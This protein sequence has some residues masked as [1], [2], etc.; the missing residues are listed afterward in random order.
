[1]SSPAADRSQAMVALLR[2]A[3]SH[4]RL[5]PVQTALAVLGVALGVCL[6]VGVDLANGTA[7]RAF[8]WS[9]AGVAG[10]ATHQIVGTDLGLPDSTL[11]YLR[12]KQGFRQLAP[13]VEASVGLSEAPG[14]AF[15]LI[16]IDPL[17]EAP[18]RPYLAEAN[19]GAGKQSGSFPLTE[20]LTLP[21]TV[22]LSTDVAQRLSLQ[23]GDSLSIET[24]GHSQRVAL[25]AT[26]N[27]ADALSRRALDGLVISDIATAQELLGRTGRLT[28]IDA[29]V[30]SPAA[31]DSLIAALPSGAR[32]ER[33]SA[34]TERLDQMSSAFRQNLHALSLLA[35]VVAVLLIY[36]TTTF[37]V[38]RRWRWLGMLRALG[39]S[40]RE[41]IAMVLA[42]ALVVGGLGAVLGLGGGIWLAQVL[43]G[44]VAQSLNDLYFSV[45][46]GSV[47]L[48]PAGLLRGLAL[49][50]GASVLGA[51]APA[52]EAA[53]VAPRASLHRSAL[54]Q[55]WRDR[56]PWLSGIGLV[57]MCGGALLTASTESLTGSYLGLLCAVLGMAALSPVL[58]IGILR[59]AAGVLGKPLGVLGRLAA[60]DAE[61]SL[62]RT[63]VAVAA[64][65]VAV[66]ATIGVGVMVAS[67]RTTVVTWLT[68]VLDADV[69]ISPPSTVARFNN[70]T[71]DSASVARLTSLRGSDGY[72]GIR[73]REISIAGQTAQLVATD[74]PERSRG[75]YR[76]LSGSAPEVWN[77]LAGGEA[78]VSEP[79][80]RR[81]G[82]EVGDTVFLPTPAGIAPVRV[83]A[84]YAD[85]GSDL[86]L[87][88]IQ[89]QTYLRLFGDSLL[90]GL[91]LYAANGVSS[92]SLAALAREAASGGQRLF[93]RSNRSLLT[94]SLEVFDRTFAVTHA[95]WLL[96]VLVAFVGVLSA[97]LSLELERSRE[98][99]V[100]RASGL[101]PGQL[102]RLLMANTALLGLAAGLIALPIGL[103]LAWAL[104]FVINLRSFGWSLQFDVPAILLLQAV[105]FAVVAAVLAGLWPAWRMSRVPVAEA[106]RD[107]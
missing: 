60:R 54:E 77:R 1:M 101:T 94:E 75:K 26:L 72:M 86:G 33:T 46:V 66:G 81:F 17:S 74:I 65:A 58:V 8:A 83:A 78:F 95:L 96:T 48:E 10:R 53:S 35:L 61:A 7:T 49:G 29:V 99:A 89:R 106:L 23:L 70:G 16:G 22:L 107:E 4:L 82:S 104:V 27:P 103:V 59:V 50:V 45:S 84:V 91:A 47:V 88:L 41:L 11:A 42:E 30:A 5:H 19:A 20:L 32:I 24:E 44:L 25:V 90:S 6:A 92:D 2:T 36:N 63:G 13:V 93:I 3:W 80:F 18:I 98:L 51:L 14:Q 62:S 28:R 38:V 67:F 71:L 9:T 68:G 57:L 34:R 76:F 100:L 56:L 79:Y 39:V 52:L 64:L 40:R 21:R 97:L 12:V 105:V 102:A 31:L 87:V 73:A 37:S 15:T 55:R 85:F 69:Y 43:T